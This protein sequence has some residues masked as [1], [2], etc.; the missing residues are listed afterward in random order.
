MIPVPQG[1]AGGNLDPYMM[2]L[3]IR[4]HGWVD[5]GKPGVCAWYWGSVYVVER[6]T[7]AL[8]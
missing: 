6:G 3:Y 7:A 5:R 2:A 1:G 8:S 4:F